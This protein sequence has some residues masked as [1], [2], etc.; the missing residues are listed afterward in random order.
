MLSL[1]YFLVLCLNLTLA[2]C[3]FATPIPASPIPASQT[4]LPQVTLTPTPEP[5][6]IGVP[7]FDFHGSKSELAVISSV[8]GKRLESFT[9][10]PIENS[11]S[12]TFAP[13]GHT[14][15]LIANTNLYLVDLP[16]WKIREYDLDLGGWMSFVIY[17]A[18]G[19]LL[20]IA[21]GEPKSELWI[22]NPKNGEVI[23]NGKADIS[24]RKAQFTTDGTGL[25]VY[26][27]QIAST[28]VA[29]NA[30]VSVDSPKAVLYSVSDLSLVWSTELDGIRDGTFPK[31]GELANTPDIYLP[32]AASHYEPG[33]AFSSKSDILYLVHADEDKVT[34]VDF[35]HRKV[36]RMDVHTKTSWF[37]Q[38]M[39]L[40]ASVAY[41]K[42]MDGTIKQAFLSSDGKY[43]FV[44]G[45][46]ETVTQQ[47]NSIDWSI[48]DTPLGLQ[49]IAVENGELVAHIDMEATLTGLSLDGR[50]IFLTAW[51]D[52]DNYTFPR[53][54][55]YDTSFHRLIKQIDHVYLTS[56]RRIDGEPMLVSTEYT[57]SNGEDLCNLATV[58]PASWTVVNRW[59]SYC[60]IW[61]TIP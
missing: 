20:A 9:P 25:M 59:E 5:S 24:I 55:V 7:V 51:K 42:G 60:V 14:L 49:V 3:S 40:T 16:V 32:G 28:G 29:A 12:Y 10:L 23:A 34:V 45:N 6:G 15:A 52:Q 56:T 39:A 33:K 43:L 38:L 18:D 53:T 36:N 37:D 48:T 1:R 47:A 22:I 58:D 54:D 19:S 61:L 4:A 17:S 11:Y 2:A 50:Q 13:D 26:G 31:K 44:G 41:A 57:G 27:P 8:T 35:N 46:T 21:S 30:G